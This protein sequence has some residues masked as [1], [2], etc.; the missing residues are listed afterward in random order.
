M[1]RGLKRIISQGTRK[2]KGGKE[3]RVKEVETKRK[4]DK[5]GDRLK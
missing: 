3:K 4:H 2:K 1:K 5:R